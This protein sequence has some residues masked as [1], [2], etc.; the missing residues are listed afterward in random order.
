MRIVIADD[1]ML[2]RSGL[3]RL[4]SEV[5][6]DVVAEAGDAATLLREVDRHRPD[7]AVVDIR[8][9]PTFT[10]EGLVAT[11]RIRRL[12]PEVAVVLLSQHLETRYAEQL[13]TDQ[14]GG[15]AYLLKE[16]VTEIGVLVDAMRR[17]SGGECVLDPTIVSQLMRRR[18]PRTVFDRLTP[19][20]QEVLTAM[21]E[22]RSNAGIAAELGLRERTVEAMS[23][24]IFQKLAL[25]PSPDDNRRV[26]AVLT[27]LR[28]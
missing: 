22:G 6:V 7:A 10:D 21:A 12:Y 5:G 25:A 24:Q 27:F 4:L 17:V 1:V 16:R 23:S 13:L 8:M 15:I 20:E 2:V 28:S 19:R 14:P 26:L 11:D 3:A 18:K 9:P